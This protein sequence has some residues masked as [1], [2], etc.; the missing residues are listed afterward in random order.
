[1]HAMKRPRIT[2]AHARRSFAETFRAA[3]LESPDLDARV[4]VGHVLGLNHTGLA[5]GADL[6][7]APEDLD[8][9]LPLVSR[10]LAGEPVARILGRKEFWGLDLRLAPATLVPR[11]ET[12]TVVAAALDAIKSAGTAARALRI[13]DLGTGSGALLLA[14]L[15]ELPQAIGVGTDASVS[16]LA[17][18]RRNAAELGL[19]RRA[20]FVACDFGAALVGEFDLVVSNPP[21]IASGDIAALAPEVREHD[22][23]LA[24]DGGADGL[25]AYRVIAADAHR[26][27]ARQGHLVVE[28]G[29][30]QEAAVAALLTQAELA[31][32]GVRPDLAGI[33]R[34]LIARG[35]RP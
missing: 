2:I 35:A 3:G 17:I 25:A 26:L 32:A 1:M 15:S 21:Y 14:L 31:V 12:E 10:R 19:V 22:P 28:L 34:V 6:V 29:A 9:I 8:A 5:T 11:P 20:A 7:L 13:A 30:G 18:A 16:A 4:L 23:R 33:P 27:L 24:L